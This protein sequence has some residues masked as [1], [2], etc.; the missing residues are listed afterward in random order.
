[1]TMNVIWIITLCAS[2]IFLIQSILTFIGAGGSD[3]DTDINF[4]GADADVPDSIAGGSGMGLLTFRNLVN[5]VLGF[6]WAFILLRERIASTTVLSIVSVLVGIVLVVAVMYLFKWVSSLQ[7]TG[8]I[9]LIK[10]APGCKGTVYLTI[11]E[12]RTGEGKVQITINNSVREY[13]A[14]TDGPKISTGSAIT[15]IE[16][17]NNSLLLVK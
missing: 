11:P 16:A 13:A 10:D 7:Q 12:A 1:M 6:G 8:T 3:M 15:V 2:G 4:D 5:F 17:V 14:V 9:N